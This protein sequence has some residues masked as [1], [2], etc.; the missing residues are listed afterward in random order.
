M[1]ILIVKD[2]STKVPREVV[3]LAAAQAV[4]E[5]GFEVQVETEPGSNTFVPLADAI[6]AAAPPAEPEPTAKPRKPRAQE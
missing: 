3:D 5:S 6:A 1:L 4:A 2:S